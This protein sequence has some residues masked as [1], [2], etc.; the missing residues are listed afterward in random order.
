[1]RMEGA[2]PPTVPELSRRITVETPE[3]VTLDFELAGPGSRAAAAVIDGLIVGAVLV[4]LAVGAAMTG[5]AGRLAFGWI[6]A[7]LIA[8]SFML[9]WGYFALFEAWNGGRTPGK[10]YVGIR[11]VLDTGHPVT[12]SAAVIRNLVRIVDLQPGFSFAVGALF[13]VFHPSNKRLGD[14][15]AGTIVVRDRPEDVVLG[16]AAEPTGAA[17]A[18][19]PLHAEEPLLED[20]EYRLLEQLINRLDELEPAR[21]VQFVDAVAARFMDRFLRREA[22]A[23]TFLIGLYAAEHRRRRSRFAARRHTGAGRTIATAESFVARK[24]GSWEAFRRLAAETEARGLALL[25]GDEVVT[26]ASQYREVAADLARARTYGVD[27]RVKSYLERVVSAGHNALYG[28]RRKPASLHPLR[29][30]RNF[31]EAV[32]AARGY[33]L[34]S[35]LM[36]SLPAVVGYVLIREQPAVAYEVLP[37]AMIARAESGASRLAAG[38]GY[39]EAPSPYLPALASQIVANNLQVAFA[40]FAFGIT[41][42]I[43]TLLVL[44]FNGLFF[45]AVLGL[46]A[47]TELAGWLLTFVA[48]HGVL[49]LAAIFIAGGAGLLI[50]RAVIAPGDLPRLDALVI[51]GRHAIRMVGAAASLLLLAGAIEGFLSAS[52]APGGIKLAVSGASVVLLGLLGVV[53]RRENRDRDQ[54]GG[55]E[56]G[57]GG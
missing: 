3:H 52:D 20:D 10:S 27:P 9:V 43:G 31:A 50:G 54:A 46:F 48:G 1:M 47:N 26:F 29:W 51:H 2:R 18:P 36:F 21:R 40:A 28:T 57:V 24:Q 53:G 39:A 38:R 16:S 22:D 41:A 7:I 19:E 45:G 30:V 4:L 56:L 32:Y 34:T 12:F 15:V 11:V 55:Q 23:E 17:D 37:D 8:A 6:T 35:F 13:A 5:F 44:G 42:G 49:E 33:V 14:L 25:T